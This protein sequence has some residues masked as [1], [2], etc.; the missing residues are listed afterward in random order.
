[1]GCI[2]LSMSQLL[3]YNTNFLPSF[4][5]T[6]VLR[7]APIVLERAP[8]YIVGRVPAG[9]VVDRDLD[10][11]VALRPVVE[12]EHLLPQPVA[13]VSG[14]RIFPDHI[15]QAACYDTVPFAGLVSPIH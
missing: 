15:I 1:M 4:T 13:A 8:D 7:V 11:P 2:L 5:T 12:H 9:Q 6:G 14:E 10:D 3:R